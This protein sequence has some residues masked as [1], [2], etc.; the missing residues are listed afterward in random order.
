MYTF[1]VLTNMSNMHIRN[2]YSIILIYSHARKKYTNR[3]IE[4]K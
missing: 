3:A 1:P 2:K 4:Q